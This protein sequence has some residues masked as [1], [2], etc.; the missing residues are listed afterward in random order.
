MNK[1]AIK[2]YAIWARKEL[3]ERVAQKAYQYGMS[4]TSLPEYNSE[5]INGNLLNKE[6][7]KQLNECIT[8]IQ[9][10]KKTILEGQK[11]QNEQEALSQAFHHVI[12]EV[13]Y[14]WFNRF[15]ALRFMEVNNYLPQ[16]VK[17]FTNEE[18]EFKPEILKEAIH[19]EMDGL[20]KEKVS[21]FMDENKEEELY[22]YLLLT[23]CND[24]NQYLP[25]M[26]TSISDYKTLL[27][28]DHLL[29]EGSI[30][31]RLVKD[32]QE[33]DWTNQVQ[34]IGWLYQYYNSELKDLVM[35]KKNYT[36][37][38]IPAATQLFT[39]DWI[40]RY[41]TENSLVRLWKDGH[42]DFDTS[43]WKY[44]LEQAQQEKE[45]E[46]ELKTYKKKTGPIKYKS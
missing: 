46:E 14:T 44:Y 13:A 16:K 31:D 28:P 12:E 1:T 38:D 39:P 26:F 18:N 25:E 22:K 17:V 45:V 7:I 19:L 40:V 2:N 35:K 24:M 10:E 30:L 11:K 29:R 15:I 43:S 3:M 41:M 4:E 36:K 5:S 9:K 34:I 27:F 42:P 6:E 21:K 20:D 37:D 23:L 8:I 32:I 33:E